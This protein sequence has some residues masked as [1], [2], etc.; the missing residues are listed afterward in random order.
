VHEE[1]TRFGGRLV[2][3]LG[4]SFLA[5]FDGPSRAIRCGRAILEQLPPSGLEM[6]AGIHTGECEAIAAELDGIPVQI[7]SR[8]GSQARPSELL[9]SATVRDLVA[10]SGI[11]FTDRGTHE[12]KE[13][14]GH[15]HLHAVA[16]DRE[17][18]ARPVN[19]VDRHAAMLTP[20]PR[21]TM[22]PIDRAA[23]SLAKHAPG[24][25]RLGFRLM[26]LRRRIVRDH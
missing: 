3:S 20:G 6:R 17:T 7:S 22:R 8:I 16:A 24:I 4:D 18:D 9:V 25:S 21:D 13:I 5:A 14:A 19:S 2:K 12:F 26:P 11:E 10:G 1:L 15:W 23:V